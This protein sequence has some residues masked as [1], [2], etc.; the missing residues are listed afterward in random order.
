MQ[1]LISIVVGAAANP[2]RPQIQIDLLQLH[3][4]IVSW[5]ED[6]SMSDIAALT[7]WCKCI[8]VRAIQ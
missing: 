7:S 6:T 5:K 3:I 1:S 2:E 4:D 8:R